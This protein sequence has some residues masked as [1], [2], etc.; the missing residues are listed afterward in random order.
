MPKRAVKVYLSQ[1]QFMML[2]RICKA[3]GVDYSSFFEKTLLEYAE[4][5]GVLKRR[6]EDAEKV[7]H[8]S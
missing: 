1:Q 8:S 6:L 5:T 2:E 4:R 3:L 7:S